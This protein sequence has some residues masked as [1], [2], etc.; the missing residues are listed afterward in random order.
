[1]P[2]SC[3]AVTSF[4]VSVPVVLSTTFILVV[5][6]TISSL[7]LPSALPRAARSWLSTP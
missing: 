2:S 5:M 7:N 1:M 3:S 4:S 6:G